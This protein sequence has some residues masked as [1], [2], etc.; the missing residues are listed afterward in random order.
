MNKEEIIT[1]LQACLFSLDGCSQED[2][3]KLNPD[4]NPKCVK[5]GCSLCSYLKSLEIEQ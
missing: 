4:Y 1:T 2:I 5:V 3:I